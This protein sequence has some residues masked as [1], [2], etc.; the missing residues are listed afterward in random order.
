MLDEP[1]GNPHEDLTAIYFS[2]AEEQVVIAQPVLRDCDGIVL[3]SDL[4][5]VIELGYAGGVVNASVVR[6]LCEQHIV[7]AEFAGVRIEIFFRSFVP[8]G[9]VTL[10]AE[11]IGAN[12][13]AVIVEARQTLHKS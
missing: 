1:I 6:F 8:E 2:S 13:A 3:S 12:D 9:K 10:P 11:K 4:A 5:A 7:L